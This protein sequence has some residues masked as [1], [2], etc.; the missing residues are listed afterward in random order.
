MEALADFIDDAVDDCVALVDKL[1]DGDGDEKLWDT[2][3]AANEVEW[4]HGEVGNL[5][6]A[7]AWI[8]G[9]YVTL[10]MLQMPCSMSK[11]DWLRDAVEERVKHSELQLAERLSFACL[12]VAPASTEADYA[13]L[14]SCRNVAM[15]AQHGLMDRLRL[16]K[17]LLEEQRSALRRKSRSSRRLAEREKGRRQLRTHQKLCATRGLDCATILS[18]RNFAHILDSDQFASV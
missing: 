6:R 8:E 2:S 16:G 5:K 12:Q 14:V 13:R 15:S 10:D 11:R 17:I 18:I 3:K 4:G 1:L 9:P 7:M